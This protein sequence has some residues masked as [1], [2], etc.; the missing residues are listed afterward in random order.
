MVIWYSSNNKLVR[1]TVVRSRYGTHFM[2]SH[3]NDVEGNRYLDNVV[4]I[5][6]MYSR[7]L[8]L[9][10][11]LLARSSGPGGMGLGIKESGNLTVSDNAFIA[12]TKGVYMDTAP[13]EPDDFNT[14]ENNAFFHSEVAVL[15]H[16]SAK[17]NAFLGNQFVSN[18]SQLQVE[19]GGN[20][21]GVDWKGNSFDDY[22]GYD[23]DR[24]GFGDIPYE[25]RRLSSQLESTYPQLQF[26]RGAITLELLDAISSLFPM[27]EPQTTLIDSRP[28]MGAMEWETVDAR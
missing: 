20:A 3:G 10:D 25:L 9:R 26:F 27:V 21:L 13:L 1:N 17:R 4:G 22:A 6:I 16:S 18:H 7:N 11:N 23:M 19:G 28:R 15:M 24:D 2:Y 12:N 5:F 14:F 8:T